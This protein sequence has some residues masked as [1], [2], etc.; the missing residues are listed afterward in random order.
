MKEK[1]IAVFD[2]G[3]TNKKILLFNSEMDVVYQHATSF[4][5]TI[6]E[7]GFHCED[8]QALEQWMV[9]TIQ[10]LLKDERYEIKAL[11]FATYGASLVFLDKNGKRLTPLYNYLKEIPATVADELFNQYGGAV[12][13]CR[14]TASPALDGM[15]NAGVQILWLKE[16]RKQVYEQVHSILHLPQYFSYLFTGKIVSELTSIG[17][18]TFMWNFDDH[19]Y[20]QWISDKNIPLPKPLANSHTF[21]VSANNT[22]LKCGIGI[23]DSTASMVPFLAGSD[24]KFILISSGTWCINMNPFNTSPLTV[25]QLKNDC[26]AYISTCGESVKSS[27][28]FSGFIREINNAR[29]AD[30]FSVDEDRFKTVSVNREYITRFLSSSEKMFF[31]NGIPDDYCDNSVDLSVF[32]GYEEAYHRLLYDLSLMNKEAI[33]R[34]LSPGDDIKNIYVTGGFAGNEIFIRLL[35]TLYPDK[36]IFTADIEHAT[37]Q[38]AALVLKNLIQPSSNSCNYIK[39]KEWPEF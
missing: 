5:E 7:D 1:V 2:I 11:N 6:D 29:L 21:T 13:F 26:L 23:H 9:R 12:E 35:A 30:Y 37:S 34:I 31:S 33:D 17:C 8:I 32:S 28:I 10:S 3:K 27:R 14:S 25:E 38:G 36:R 16:Y 4:A 19:R 24:E 22:P 15:L 20:H 18:H 39:M